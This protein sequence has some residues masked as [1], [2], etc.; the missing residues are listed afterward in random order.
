[1]SRLIV[2]CVVS[3]A[4]LLSGCGTRLTA[5][6]EA[7]IAEAHDAVLEAKANGRRDSSLERQLVR[8]E[9]EVYVGPGAMVIRDN[10]PSG[11][12]ERVAITEAVPVP[13]SVIAERIGQMSGYRTIV[14]RE[15]YDYYETLK[16]LSSDEVDVQQA[17]ADPG[18]ANLAESAGLGKG[19]GPKM[20]IAFKGRL[21]DLLD[22]VVAG[23]NSYWRFEEETGTIWI[24]RYET[25]TM[26]IS[27]IN[28]TL[29]GQATM[30]NTSSTGDGGDAGQGGSNT[31][32]QTQINIFD[33]VAAGVEGLLSADGKSTVAREF[34]SVTVTDTPEVIRKVEK[35]IANVN[36]TLTQEVVMDVTVL[37]VQLSNE[38]ERGI[39]WDLVY[40]SGQSASFGMTSGGGVAS[41][42]GSLTG[43]ILNTAT[44]TAGKY[45]GSSIVVQ[46]LAR[47]GDVSVVTTATLRT[48]N[49]R[50]V[51]MAIGD[52]ITYIASSS[53]TIGDGSTT[54]AL[55]T[56]EL[57]VGF[58]LNVNP[59][60]LD[61]AETIL[62]QLGVNISQLNEL[63]TI[64]QGTSLIQ[65]PDV[66]SRDFLQSV[67]IRSGETLVIAGFERMTDDIERRAMGPSANWW[68]FGGGRAAG[69]KREVIVIVIQ[70]F[71]QNGAKR[72]ARF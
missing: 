42:V 40:N 30:S 55:N 31:Q 20:P 26:R 9:D 67:S 49:N 18:A 52:K 54:G 58:A 48:L 70:P 41:P 11:F 22:R 5:E 43:A 19:I 38:D 23:L 4:I 66:S 53:T 60:V 2:A 69:K 37:S 39:D 51:P 61:D 29:S 27:A 10:L 15:V 36:R 68:P 25:K 17:V 6:T 3:G 63:K 62:M 65:A 57:S 28:N 59:H 35:Y 44:G 56:E 7:D 24:Y 8:E 16:D 72:V 12:D 34:S 14:S 47:Q 71:V 45:A 13:I 32:S 33:A 21:R 64:T 1:M 46:N 50:P